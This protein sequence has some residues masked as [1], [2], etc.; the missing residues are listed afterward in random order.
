MRRLFLPLIFG[1]IGTAILV[2]LGV[3]QVQR[4]AWKEDILSNI[5]LRIAAE[6]RAIPDTPEPTQ[7]TYLPVETE[8]AILSGEVHVL[9]SRKHFGAGYRIIAPLQLT[10]GRVVLLDRGFVKTELKNAPRTI[11]PV[12][13]VGNLHWP[14]EKGSSIP[15]PDLAANIWFARDVPQMA[16]VLNTEPVMIIARQDSLADAT[17]TALPVD[18]TGIPNDHLQYAITWFS[19]AALWF[20]MTLAFIWRLR[21]QGQKT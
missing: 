2:S 17:M 12:Q 1:L 3:W 5:S 8:G 9:V 18:T 19:L 16:Q 7:H 21:A 20:V 11:G 4:L 14:D 6:P 10:D 13:V 15:E